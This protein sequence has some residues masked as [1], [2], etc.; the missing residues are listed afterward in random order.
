MKRLMPSGSGVRTTV[1]ARHIASRLQIY[2]LQLA[3]TGSLSGGP[4][5][6]Y[7]TNSDFACLLLGSAAGCAKGRINRS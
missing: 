4:K 2:A 3:P 5:T 1:L 7:G 6:H